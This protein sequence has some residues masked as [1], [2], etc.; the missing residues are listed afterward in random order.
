MDHAVISQWANILVYICLGLAAIIGLYKFILLEYRTAR[1]CNAPEVTVRATVYYKDPDCFPV[2]AGRTTNYVYHI[3]FHT[4]SG[5][6]LKLYMNRDAYFNI[7]EGASG[8]LL[9]QGEKLWRF[10][11]DNGTVIRQ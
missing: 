7:P 3:T 5:E 11:M 8:E 10:T 9:C 1:I 2:P 4:E 6:A